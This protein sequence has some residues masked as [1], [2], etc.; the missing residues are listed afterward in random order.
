MTR[1]SPSLPAP[2]TLYTTQNTTEG[3]DTRALADTN[4]LICALY[5]ILALLNLRT[6]KFF[7][8][9]PTIIILDLWLHLCLIP[10]LLSCV[11]FQ[12]SQGK[13]NTLTLW[14]QMS[15][16][17]SGCNKSLLITCTHTI[18]I[19]I[20]RFLHRRFPCS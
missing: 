1:S 13:L 6:G 20:V 15:S 19:L 5:T 16:L 14:F 8:F 11:S 9:P 2:N 3:I 17:L 10:K 12:S 7:L 18:K 4:F